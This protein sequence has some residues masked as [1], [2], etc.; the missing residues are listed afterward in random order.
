MLDDRM[1]DEYERIY[2]KAVMAYQGTTMHLPGG[3]EEHHKRPQSGELVSW[4]RSELSTSC[5]RLTS[6]VSPTV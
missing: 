3:I 2:K 1:T 6:S 5:T 4:L